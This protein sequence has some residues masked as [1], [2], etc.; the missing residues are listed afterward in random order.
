MKFKELKRLIR[1]SPLRSSRLYHMLR[2]EMKKKECDRVIVSFMGEEVSGDRK[3]QIVKNM[4]NAMIKYHWAFDEYFLFDY[5]GTTHE[6]RL[7]F[8]P[9]YEKNVFCD[10]VNSSKHA[11]VFLISG[12]P[13]RCLRNSSNVMLYL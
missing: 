1:L 3:K 13:T 12:K 6:E 11:D 9:E 4:R 8:V 10:K 5:E 7:K 2:F